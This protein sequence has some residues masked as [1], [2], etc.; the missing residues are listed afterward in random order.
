[1]ELLFQKRYVFLF[2]FKAIIWSL[3]LLLRNLQANYP[4]RFISKWAWNNLKVLTDIGAKVTGTY[5]NEII[6]VEFLKRDIK[7][8]IQQADSRQNI[9]MDV[10]VTFLSNYLL[11]C[12]PC[13]LVN[14]YDHVILMLYI[15]DQ[16]VSFSLSSLLV[17]FFSIPFLSMSC[18]SIFLK[19]SSTCLKNWKFSTIKIMHI[20]FNSFNEWLKYKKITA[21]Y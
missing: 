11:K 12:K 3:D 21:V 18:I 13:G 1:M 19:S 10:Q 7:H 8:I 5:G 4:H 2:I 17:L 9:E 15:G 20:L 14:F 16:P 6:A